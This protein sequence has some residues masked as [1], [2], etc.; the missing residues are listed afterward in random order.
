MTEK[1][2]GHHI[3]VA[4]VLFAALAFLVAAPAASAS[5]IQILVNDQPITSYDIQ[6]RAK[7]LQVFSRGKAGRKE[8]IDQL[9]DEKLMVQEAARK[10]ITVSDA[11]VDQEIANRARGARM[12]T[13]QFRQA[14]RQA[15]LD[16][17]SFRAFLH[18]NM[19]WKKTVG[20]RFRATVN[21][22]DQ[23]I[24]AALGAQGQEG[25][26][27]AASEYML[28]PILFIVPSGASR[29]TANSQLAAAN[30]FRKGFQGC[31]HSV[32]QASGT[33]GIVVKPQ[34]RREETAM[35]DSLRTTLARVEV[36]GTTAPEQVPEGYQIIAV[37]AKNA[38]AGE[39]QAAVAAREEI[40]GERGQLLARRYLRDLRSD[41]VI[42][43]R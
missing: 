6:Q 38:I 29:S 21:V 23:D 42:E 19:L 3:T 24:V 26:Q 13:A 31:D 12:T 27:Q 14:L 28:Q 5:S 43:Y 20:A 1:M 8:A 18:A 11:E 16:P 40:S 10:H 34:I 25:E 39:T 37:C 4:A 22:T 2:P 32:E 15:G 7:M 41:A 36:G 17:N 9:I 30:A 33:P 35:A